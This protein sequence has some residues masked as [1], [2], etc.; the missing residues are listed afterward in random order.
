ML[1]QK[2]IKG[3]QGDLT[4]VHAIRRAV[5]MD[6]QGLSEEDEFDGTDGSCLHLLICDDDLPVATGRIFICEEYFKLGRI[7][8]IM[9][10]RGRG[11]AT[12]LMQSLVG[13]CVAMGGTRQIIHSQLTARSFYETLGFTAYGEEFM[14]AGL[15]HIAMEHIGGIKN[16]GSGGHCGG[17]SKG[18]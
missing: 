1:T 4:D 5:F 18:E 7:A 13:A 9:T 10:H 6:E 14:E 15:P 17:C 3:E 2:W 8:T 16:C 11:I 12:Q